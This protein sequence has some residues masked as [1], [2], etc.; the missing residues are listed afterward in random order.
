MLAKKPFTSG[1]HFNKL[2]IVTTNF[3]QVGYKPCIFTTPFDKLP[4]TTTAHTACLSPPGTKLGWRTDE[5]MNLKAEKEAGSGP[6][7]PTSR[8]L[9]LPMISL[10][11]VRMFETKHDYTWSST[12][13]KHANF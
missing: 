12:I 6:C 13:S 7:C 3:S 2:P 4:T 11:Q 8:G 9:S 10:S 1:T 5:G